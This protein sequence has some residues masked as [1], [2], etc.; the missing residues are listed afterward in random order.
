[1]G[2]TLQEKLASLPPERRA[3]IK[4]ETTRL[5]AA[6]IAQLQHSCH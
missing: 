2:T 3:R 1:M 5:Q 4:A 6:Y